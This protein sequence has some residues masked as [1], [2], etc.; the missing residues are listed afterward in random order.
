M[1]QKCRRWLKE[2]VDGM[3]VCGDGDGVDASA[4]SPGKAVT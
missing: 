3:C 1:V 4:L 2:G